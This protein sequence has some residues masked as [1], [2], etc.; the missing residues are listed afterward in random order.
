MKR[1]YVL[2]SL[3]FLTFLAGCGSQST[4]QPTVPPGV[5]SVEI[6]YLNHPPVR[7][8][9]TQVD[10]LLKQYGDRVQVSRY[11]FDTPEGQTFAQDRDLTAHTPLAIFINGSMETTIGDRTIKFYSFPQGE[12]TGMVA[13]G[14]WTISDLRQALDEAVKNNS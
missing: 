13:E 2:F 7:P 11:D 10:D 3:I 12:G 14:A 9:L 5:T 1:Y 4:S 8:I 6:A